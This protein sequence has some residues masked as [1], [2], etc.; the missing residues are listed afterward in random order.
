MSTS[1]EANSLNVE[2]VERPNLLPGV[3]SP[4]EVVNCC[5]AVWS[6]NGS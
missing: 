1:S 4:M 2:S 3:R 5:E 6:V